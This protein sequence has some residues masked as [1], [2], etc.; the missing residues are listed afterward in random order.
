MSDLFQDIDQYN[1]QLTSHLL[2]AI[3]AIREYTDLEWHTIFNSGGIPQEFTS[4]PLRAYAAYCFR[5]NTYIVLPDLPIIRNHITTWNEIVYSTT[6]KQTSAIPI[7]LPVTSSNPDILDEVMLRNIDNVGEQLK[8]YCGLETIDLMTHATTPDSEKWVRELTKRGL[9]IN[10]LLS[11]KQYYGIEGINM[12][13]RSGFAQWA[14]EQFLPVPQSVVVFEESE[15]NQKYGQLIAKAGSPSIYAKVAAS[16]GGY[17]VSR[18]ESLQQLIVKYEEWK[19]EGLLGP[20]Y[21]GHVPVELQQEVTAGS[22]LYNLSFQYRTH[23]AMSGLKQTKILRTSP[24][25]KN[26]IQYTQQILDGTHWLGN[27]FNLQIENESVTRL[28]GKLEYRFI[29]AINREPVS[30]GGID[31]VIFD[32]LKA[33]QVASAVGTEWIDGKFGIAIIEHNGG[34]LSD[35]DLMFSAINSIANASKGIFVTS[36]VEPI[37]SLQ[38]AW[39]KI[40]NAGLN[41]SRTDISGLLIVDWIVDKLDPYGHIAIAVPSQKNPESYVRQVLDFLRTEGLCK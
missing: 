13:D 36:K 33:K 22:I 26:Y 8:T 6:S 5:P 16:G 17:G 25:I 32:A 37:I 29:N 3:F 19:Q 30:F 31:F 27:S 38:T 21:N 7:F 2:V 20:L 28:I 39:S 24:L 4:Y 11:R 9:H 1:N 34:R 40:C 14:R 35:A 23:R 18:V 41:Y 15:L 12:N 10:Q